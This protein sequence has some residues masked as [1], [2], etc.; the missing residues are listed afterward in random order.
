M[1][2]Y[3]KKM[4]ARFVA[5]AVSLS[6]LS[7]STLVTN[8]EAA[9]S[10]ASHELV[11][12]TVELTQ[13]ELIAADYHVEVPIYIEGG[14][15]SNATCTIQYDVELLAYNSFSAGS[16]ISGSF[17]NDADN[18][19]IG[20]CSVVIIATSQ[21]A[22]GYIGSVCFDVSSNVQP[23]DLIQLT[24]Y[25]ENSNVDGDATDFTN[26]AIVIAETVMETTTTTTTGNDYTT[27]DGTYTTTTTTTDGNMCETTYDTNV[28]TIA[29]QSYCDGC[30]KI[31]ADGEGVR[32]PLGMFLC[33]ECLDAGMGGT[34]PPANTSVTTA[35]ITT[36]TTQDEYT[37]TG[38]D[39]TS[40]VTTQNVTTTT[41]VS[42]TTATASEREIIANAYMFGMIGADSC[43]GLSEVN[44]SSTA[45]YITGDG[46]YTVEWVISGEG[47]DKL[48][49]LAVCLDPADG[50]DFTRVTYPDLFIT[51]DQVWVDGVQFE[52]YQSSANAVN[53]G[54]YESSKG[55]TRIYLHDEW[56]G[57]GV[58]DI[59]DD[60]PVYQSVKVVFTVG[61]LGGDASETVAGIQVKS[62]TNEETPM[63]FA[64][65]KTPLMFEDY[66]IT[67]V[68]G[69]GTPIDITEDCAVAGDITP[70]SL[71][72][73]A[74]N[75]G[76][77]AFDFKAYF[78]YNGSNEAVLEYLENKG[79][80]KLCSVELCVGQ[81]GDANLDHCVDT[82]DAA[83]MARYC[84]VAAGGLDTPILSE[85]DNAVALFV[86]D[87][88]S[89][90][91]I[92]TKDAAMSA[93]YAAL[94]A[95]SSSD[96]EAQKNYDI[97]SE[98]LAS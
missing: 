85:K 83:S 8:V 91:L 70:Y 82:K 40:V 45:A 33:S 48:Q 23:G 2:H 73:D 13:E 35:V 21:I 15:W 84:A 89:D 53:Y 26:G 95:S 39:T 37:T 72:W 78:E 46:Q 62:N 96:D 10:A 76:S 63:F 92:D 30:G 50:D 3:F 42:T 52:G 61:G 74:Y 97:W 17:W 14:S 12:S 66:T 43:W 25:T 71:Y 47:A 98:L 19:A 90:G 41:A 86:G 79:T 11:I 24:W 65:D 57:T 88:N 54:Y 87:T 36:G 49:F 59:P 38:E 80:D 16:L 29:P 44:D 20:R 27:T 56:A 58:K 75:M 1:K 5:A 22:Q 4:L 81:R 60:M 67:A 77:P 9:A 34:T 18:S 7:L 51:V 93:K 94:Y 69:D 64:D 55:V 31:L 68:M 32:T 28:T 6:S